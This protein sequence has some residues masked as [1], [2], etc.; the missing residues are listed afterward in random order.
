MSPLP[1]PQNASLLTDT[2]VTKWGRGGILSPS[3]ALGPQLSVHRL[4]P[5]LTLSTWA[6]HWTPQAEGSG[7][8]GCSRHYG[9]RSQA[10]GPRATPNFC[11]T[12]LRDRLPPWVHFTFRAAPR[13][14]GNICIYQ[15]IKGGEKG[16]SEDPSE[17]IRRARSKRG[18]A[19]TGASVPTELRRAIPVRG[20]VCP[21]GSSPNHVLSGFLWRLPH[22]GTV[23]YELHFQPHSPLWRGEEV[24][25]NSKR[26]I[27]DQRPAP[28]HHLIGTKYAPRLL[29]I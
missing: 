21:P 25:E 13:I 26:P 11:P 6:E 24:A 17:E 1:L 5:V 29:S 12:W 18:L 20:C 16:L 7:P 23:N 28:S 10:L 3:N 15:F 19:S 2:V 8:Q 22:G 14:R 27:T 9:C 4:N